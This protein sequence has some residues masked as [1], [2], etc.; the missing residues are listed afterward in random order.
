MALGLKGIDYKATH[1]VADRIICSAEIDD[2][3]VRCPQC[4]CRD[5]SFKGQK[6][7]IKT[8]KEAASCSYGVSTPGPYLKA[9]FDAL[10]R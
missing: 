4:G 10:S 2:Q 1:F 7:K 6:H 9:G 3:W 8:L 5:T